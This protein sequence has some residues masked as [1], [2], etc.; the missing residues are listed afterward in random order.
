VKISLH[1]YELCD[2]NCFLNVANFINSRYKENGMYLEQE[3]K[4]LG[5][6][7]FLQFGHLEHQYTGKRLVLREIG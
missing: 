5:G 1:I 4:E 7:L 6:K 2:L 3:E